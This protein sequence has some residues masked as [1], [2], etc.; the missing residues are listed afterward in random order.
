M[1]KRKVFLA[2]LNYISPG[3]AWTIIP[4]PLNIGYLAAYA[5][6]MLGEDLEVRLFKRPAKLLE[7]LDSE[8][9]DL[10]GFSNYIWNRNLH[11]GFA[12]QVKSLHPGCITVMGGPNYNFAEREW[13][14]G[15]VR[16]APEIDFHID[17][18][19][20]VRFCNLAACCLEHGFDLDA[21]RAAAPAGSA[22]LEPRSGA[23]VSRPLAPAPD[24]WS[25]LDGIGLDPRSGRLKDLDDIPSPY[26][27][28]VLDEFLADP[29]F[30]P[31]IET[32]RGCPFSC[33]FCNWG[34]M[35]KSKSA[36]FS[37]G[38]VAAE[39][40]CIASR[41]VSKTPYLYVGDA[42]F[43]LFPRDIEIARTLRKMKDERGFPSTVYM[44]FAKNVSE[45]VVEIAELLKDMT[46]I[47]LSRQT[48]NPEVLKVIKRS[49]ISLETY[50]K[51]AALAR[52]LG[53]DSKT[54]MIYCLPGES[55]ESFYAGLRQIMEQEVDG[56]HL[57][58]AMLLDG[59]AMG[60]RE[61]RER[62]GIRGE[63]RRIEGCVGRFGPVAAAEFEEIVTATSVM[64]REDYLEVRVFHLL[65]VLFMDTK[66]Y[67]DVEAVLGGR[68]LFDLIHDLIA[69]RDRAPEPFQRVI[70]EFIQASKDELRPSPPERV[71]DAEVAAAAD[72]PSKLNNLFV[73]KL[74]HDPGVRPAFHSFL[75]ARL[76]AAGGAPEREV[77]AVL[78]CIEA[79]IYPFDG[80][81]DREVS[82]AFD[83]AAF[84]RR[85]PHRSPAAP[86]LLPEP[87][88]FRYRKAFTYKEFLDRMDPGLGMSRKI[89]NA[90]TH[91]SH[92]KLRY[93][94]LYRLEAGAAG[95]R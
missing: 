7:A 65:Q 19:G 51:L 16:R 89:Y 79:T 13:L 8:R 84:G 49:N 70:A 46:P 81:S 67:R 26:L 76:L 10:V 63:W 22:F 24:A 37:T 23:L 54:E 87:R 91:H 45:R 80:S 48:Q 32:N 38:R 95:S 56:I 92:E 33:I 88:A 94:L 3:R 30:C 14:E 64:S 60:R 83:T 5:G 21:V 4:F 43:G 41:N 25:R 47:S 73:I 44:Y 27:T 17:G 59:S 15:F 42:N 86:F 72:A 35:G 71:T 61:I 11:L 39:L 2:D 58:P 69:H 53:V 78:G 34:D 66:I 52:K 29:D 50:N 20:E 6:K 74:L 31:I 90:I 9:P 36:F 93:A 77:D 28:G 68:P 18:E 85:G 57:F 62:Y 55:K 75:R 12:R 1:K 82:M 40:D